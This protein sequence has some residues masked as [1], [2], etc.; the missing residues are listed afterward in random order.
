MDRINQNDPRP[1]QGL[2]Q[3]HCPECGRNL[4][5]WSNPHEPWCMMGKRWRAGM[6]NATV[7]DDG[8]PATPLA[9]K[10]EPGSWV[11]RALVWLRIL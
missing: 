9:Y 10:E 5:E 3:A 4:G 1:Q 6:Q 2:Q 11:H 7:Y 8:Y